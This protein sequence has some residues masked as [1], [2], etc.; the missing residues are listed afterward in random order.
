MLEPDTIWATPMSRVPVPSVTTKLETSMTTTKNALTAPASRQT[1]IATRHASQMFQPWIPASTG[2]SVA[3]MP[4]TEAIDRS[5]S[6]TTRVIIADIA[7]NTSTCWLPK[8]D[9][10]APQEPNRVGISLKYTKDIAIQTSTS[11]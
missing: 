5:N 3:E 2:T 11:A 6:P 10:K 9:E 8:I 7:R 1:T 4:M